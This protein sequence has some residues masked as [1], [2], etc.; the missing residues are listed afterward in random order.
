MQGCYYSQLNIKKWRCSLTLVRK[1]SFEP[2][3]IIVKVWLMY[4]FVMQRAHGP[5]SSCALSHMDFPSVSAQLCASGGQLLQTVLLSLICWLPSI[6]FGQLGSLTWH[7]KGRRR[8]LPWL[9]LCP[10]V[11]SLGVVESTVIAPLP[12]LRGPPYL[13]PFPICPRSGNSLPWVLSLGVSPPLVCFLSF[14]KLVSSCPFTKV[15]I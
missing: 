15:S 3:S 10:K 8:V 2:S 1:L 11:K 6:G 7:W 14:A 4:F 12:L 5:Y 13:F 9:S